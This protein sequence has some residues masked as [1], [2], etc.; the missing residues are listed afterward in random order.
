MLG[1]VGRELSVQP[2]V[3]FLAPLR[4]LSVL[5]LL[6]LQAPGRCRWLVWLPF[7]PV[8]RVAPRPSSFRRLLSSQHHAGCLTASDGSHGLGHLACSPGWGVYLPSPHISRKDS[9][10][11]HM[12]AHKYFT[13]KKSHKV[14]QF[15]VF[16]SQGRKLR[17]Q[18]V[19]DV[20]RVTQPAGVRAVSRIVCICPPHQGQV[21]RV[22]RALF[23]SSS[24][25]LAPVCHQPP[26]LTAYVES[27]VHVERFF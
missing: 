16:I 11:D 25:R 19:Q 5:A 15:G 26:H 20:L 1:P 9:S 17:P 24:M 23:V 6:S 3:C 12:K 10:Q 2:A 4:L 27:N 8:S 18:K 21:S 7:R 14:T 22:A 13:W